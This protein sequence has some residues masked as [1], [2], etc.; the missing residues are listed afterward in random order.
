[1]AIVIEH[2]SLIAELSLS[3][4][5]FFFYPSHVVKSWPVFICSELD[6]VIV[7]HLLANVQNSWLPLTLAIGW[8]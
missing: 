1:M 3:V 7:T 5:F 2:G 6:L 4:I 8:F